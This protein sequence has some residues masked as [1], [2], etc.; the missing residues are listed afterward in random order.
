[1]R[2][3]RLHSR[4]NAPRPLAKSGK[5]AGGGI[6]D[7]PETPVKLIPVT[8]TGPP[9][10]APGVVAIET[11]V[12]SVVPVN[13][14]SRE[15][16]SGASG[17]AVLVTGKILGPADTPSYLPESYDTTGRQSANRESNVREC[18]QR[19]DTHRI[20]Y[21][22]GVGRTDRDGRG[23]SGLCERGSVS[24]RRAADYRN[25]CG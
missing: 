16:V 21:D 19:G 22:G 5:E 15:T 10:L 11:D 13:V 8:V 18:C 9:K 23:I 24:D 20:T 17:L 2:F 12:K 4:P 25:G 7:S 3:L 14:K 1:L 6:S